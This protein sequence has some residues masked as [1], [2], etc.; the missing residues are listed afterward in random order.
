MDA[1]TR[2]W[3]REPVAIISAIVVLIE[4]IIGTSQQ[5]YVASV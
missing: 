4:T 3:T 1:L 2:I 5:V